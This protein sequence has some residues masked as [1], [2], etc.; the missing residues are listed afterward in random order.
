MVPQFRVGP[1]DFDRLRVMRFTEIQN[2]CSQGIV[3]VRVDTEAQGFSG[4]RGSNE[5]GV[6]PDSFSE[7]D[8][9]WIFLSA[10]FVICLQKRVSDYTFRV[11]SI[12]L[13]IVR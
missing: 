9:T 3:S 12:S 7:W 6:S 13:R 8:S 10:V 11:F 5:Q 2:P 4:F 1:R